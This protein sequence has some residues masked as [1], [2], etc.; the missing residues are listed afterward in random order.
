MVNELNANLP[1]PHSAFNQITLTVLIHETLL[2]FVL[3]K[4]TW[5]ATVIPGLP[6]ITFLEVPSP[7]L[8][9]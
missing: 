4:N 8:Q 9:I 3:T 6:Y 2:R 7:A 5:V 1:L